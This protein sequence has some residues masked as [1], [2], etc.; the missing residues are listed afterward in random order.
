MKSI[1]NFDILVNGGVRHSCTD[2]KF[3]S[4]AQGVHI[5]SYLYSIFTVFICYQPHCL[6][7]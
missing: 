2:F 7:S 5:I 6:P 1:L 3:P 4:Y